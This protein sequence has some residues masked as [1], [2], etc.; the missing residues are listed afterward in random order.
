MFM[1]FSLLGSAYSY[2]ALHSMSDLRN[3]CIEA[4]N[5]D[6]MEPFKIKL[7]C[8]GSF[9]QVEREPSN[10]DL[11]KDW[12]MYTQTSTKCGRYQTEESVYSGFSNQSVACAVVEV[13]QVSTP[14]GVGVP[15]EITNCSELTEEKADAIC[16]AKVREYCADNT[17]DENVNSSSEDVSSEGDNTCSTGPGMCTVKTVRTVNTCDAYHS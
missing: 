13:K 9:P 11:E 5:H 6:Q 16:R 14:E 12:A 17:V 15:V 1:A 3:K 10:A 4:R 8:S 7:D 2:A